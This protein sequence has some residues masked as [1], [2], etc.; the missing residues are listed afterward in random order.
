[1]VVKAVDIARELGLSKATV[2]LALNDK[3]GVNEH[4]KELVLECKRRLERGEAGEQRTLSNGRADIIKLII[5]S[6][7]YRIV[8]EAELDLWT[9]EKA[10]FTRIANSWGCKLDI[11]YFDVDRDSPE[12]LIQTCNRD[13]V[14][15]VI[16]DGTEII[17]ADSRLVNRIHKPLVLYD[18]DLYNQRHSCVMMDNRGG[19]YDA[20]D[21]LTGAGSKNIVYLAMD[22]EIYNFTSRRASFV[23]YMREHNLDDHAQDRMVRVGKSIAEVYTKFGHY[24]DKNP[25]PDAFI[26]ESYHISISA[27]RLFRERGIRLPEDVSFTGVDELPDFLTGEYAL[28]TVKIPMTERAKLTMAMLKHEIEEPCELKTKLYTACNFIHGNTIR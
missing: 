21:A 6:H 26:A 3:P 15:G 10:V 24:L 1:M 27:L 16:I 14:L 9:D 2:S 5:M 20:M 11:V 7:S 25:L 4:T 28:S 23:R 19:I 8:I 12:S 22:Y 17:T 13:D 18:V